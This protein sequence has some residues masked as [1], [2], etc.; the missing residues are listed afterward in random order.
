M[1][2]SIVNKKKNLQ[3]KINY[4]LDNVYFDVQGFDP[5]SISESQIVRLLT[6]IA[7][8]SATVLWSIIELKNL[9]KLKKT[10]KG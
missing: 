8:G 3:D 9:I 1:N 4:S 10:S 6:K 2:E 7:V 5:S